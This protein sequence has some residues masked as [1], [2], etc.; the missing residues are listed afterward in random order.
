M[1]P[2]EPPRSSPPAGQVRA[3]SAGRALNLIGD[4]WI[5][6]ILRQAFLGVRRFEDFQSR[7]GLARSLLTDRLRRLEAGGVV[8]RIRYQARP[9]RDE[10]RLTDKGLDLYDSAL[11][12][13]RWE[14]RWHLDPSQATHRLR[15]S[16]G[17]VFTPEYRCA[18]C[19]E[20][21]TAR[22]VRAEDG[23]GAGFDP[24]QKPRAQRRSIVAGG[25]LA[26][27][28]P[29]LERALQVLGDRWTAHLIAAAFQG[30]RR[31]GA[32]QRALSVASNI[33]G[34]R[35]ARLTA[36]GVLEKRPDP[37]QP[38]RLQYRLTPEGLDLFPLILAQ[39]RWGD[40]WLVGPEGPPTLIFHHACGQRLVG[41]V[42]CDQ[43][44]G[45]VTPRDTQFAPPPSLA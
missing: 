8:R 39:I 23:P 41:K 11:M 25:D 9:P 19:G 2:D 15:H 18:A 40:R 37:D 42:T 21:V 5:L 7:I 17:Q 4:R 16:C 13:I 22:D 30:H 10:Y 43:C 12:L 28:D 34:D 38:T 31:F 3:N 29:M 36:L 24:A 14:K 1:G 33:L 45:V 20:I 44:G 6:M 35:L 32:L 26:G 27:K